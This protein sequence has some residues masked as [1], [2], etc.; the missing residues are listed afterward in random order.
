[1]QRGWRTWRR[2]RQFKKLKDRRFEFLF[3]T[4]SERDV[5][6]CFD[7]ETTGLNPR[8]DRIITLTAFK[9]QGNQV[10]ASEALT[11]FFEQSQ[12]ISP[13]SIVVHRIRNQD[14]LEQ[15]SEVQE[16][17]EAM[18]RFLEFI[19]GYPLVGY[20]LEFDVAMINRVVKPWLGIELP[21]AQI[22]V[23]ELYY[24]RRLEEVKHG[25]AQPNIDLKFDTILK[26][27]DIPNL[28]Q[29]DAFNDALMTALIFLK[30]Q[31]PVKS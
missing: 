8:K 24:Q 5:A 25:M 31:Q 27:L 4:P 19:R 15:S 26:R 23:S 2:K 16:E 11:L 21:N 17:R 10:L 14:L 18:A 6:V 30:L 3:E 20:Y 1:M 22:E 28:G 7:C 12:P 13:Q 9:I 29:H